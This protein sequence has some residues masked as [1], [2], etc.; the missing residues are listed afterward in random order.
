MLFRSVAERIYELAG[1]P[2]TDGARAAIIDYLAHH[3]RNRLGSLVTSAE[4]FG[5]DEH[6]LPNRFARYRE[7]FLA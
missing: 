2:L 7:R 6:D 1:E 5:L 3:Q 4:M